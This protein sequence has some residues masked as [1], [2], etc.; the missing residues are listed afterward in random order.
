MTYDTR[1]IIGV[2]QRYCTCVECVEKGATRWQQLAASQSASQPDYPSE[3]HPVWCNCPTCAS[4]YEPSRPSARHPAPVSHDP[5]Y[6]PRTRPAAVRRLLSRS[7]KRFSLSDLVGA[8]ILAAVVVYVGLTIFHLQQGFD[9][10]SA[11]GG[12]IQDVRVVGTCFGEWGQVQDFIARDPLL[13]K[14]VGRLALEFSGGQCGS[15]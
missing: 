11:L 8:V 1:R 14:D 3:L 15:W 7:T 13:G 4:V 5:I 2:H 12:G 6:S 9:F 10:V